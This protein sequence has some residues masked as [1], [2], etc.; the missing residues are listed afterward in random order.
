MTQVLL[1]LAVDRCVWGQ[2]ICWCLV[3]NHPVFWDGQG[4]ETQ[5]ASLLRGEQTLS[6]VWFSSWFLSSLYLS[7]FSAEQTKPLTPPSCRFLLAAPLQGVIA[8]K[9][10][11]RLQSKAEDRRELIAATHCRQE[12]APLSH[13]T[14]I[15]CLAAEGTRLWL[16]AAAPV[17]LACPALTQYVSSHCLQMSAVLPPPSV[18]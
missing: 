17:E 12:E 14:P 10:D 4:K 16:A 2:V 3:E 6:L 8:V 18:H 1:F 9:G 5:R 11:P 13:C 7:D 15:L